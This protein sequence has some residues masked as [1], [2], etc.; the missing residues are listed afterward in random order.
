[1]GN[2]AHG[3]RKGY[4]TSER[5]QDPFLD[6]WQEMNSRHMVAVTAAAGRRCPNCVPEHSMPE[7][8][9]GSALGGSQP[10]RRQEREDFLQQSPAPWL[11]R[12][13]QPLSA[14]CKL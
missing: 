5:K 4:G 12:R 11:L 7:T 8:G 1:M 10:G 9:V 2:G 13:L 14:G 3:L 6:A